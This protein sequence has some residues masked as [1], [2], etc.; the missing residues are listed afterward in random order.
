MWY[1]ISPTPIP[2]SYFR[3]SLANAQPPLHIRYAPSSLAGSCEI[4]HPFRDTPSSSP[5][6]CFF[7]FQTF[8]L[9]N[10][11]TSTSSFFGYFKSN[12]TLIIQLNLCGCFSL[13][14]FSRSP[15]YYLLTGPTTLSIYQQALT[16]C[17]ICSI[18]QS[19]H[20]QPRPGSYGAIE[21]ILRI[22]EQYIHSPS[23]RSLADNSPLRLRYLYTYYS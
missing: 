8:S 13:Y 22:L 15:F 5:S 3:L 16:L 23:S 19:L 18:N 10:R 2:E 14:S 7:K 20:F 6:Y 4:K 9:L 12:I 21:Q 17:S 1:S 11:F